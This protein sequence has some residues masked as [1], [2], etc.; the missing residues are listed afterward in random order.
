MRPTTMAN[1]HKIA[2]I[3]WIGNRR[4]RRPT[5]KSRSNVWIRIGRSNKPSQ[6]PVFKAL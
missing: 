1:E 2:E 5:Q 6:L 4:K 3:K